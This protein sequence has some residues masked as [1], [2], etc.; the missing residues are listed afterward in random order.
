[1][2]FSWNVCAGRTKMKTVSLKLQIENYLNWFYNCQNQLHSL[3]LV[4]PNNLFNSWTPPRH[5]WHP[6]FPLLLLLPFNLILPL[7]DVALVTALSSIW[8]RSLRMH[9]P[10]SRKCDSYIVVRMILHRPTDWRET[11]HAISDQPCLHLGFRYFWSL[12]L[13]QITNANHLQW[14]SSSIIHSPKA[15][16]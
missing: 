9:V 10:N 14:F 4:N 5:P 16:D 13:H 2:F 15:L 3:Y 6:L 7:N 8:E 12:A 1:M 11:V